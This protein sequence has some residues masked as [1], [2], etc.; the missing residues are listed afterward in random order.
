MPKYP[1]FHSGIM[2]LGTNDNQRSK[3]LGVPKRTLQK[4][5]AGQIPANLERFLRQP[6]L[7]RA[8]AD[9]ADALNAPVVDTA[10]VSE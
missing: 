1:T 3:A 8:L 7:L 4:W 6:L 2:A 10:V 9:D 5:R